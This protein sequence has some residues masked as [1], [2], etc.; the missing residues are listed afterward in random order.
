MIG[1]DH[2][3]VLG[4]NWKKSSDNWDI[5]VNFGSVAF[6]LIM[7]WLET[8]SEDRDVVVN[9]SP[10]ALC[11]AFTDPDN[12]AT[13]LLFQLKEGVEHTKV[14]LLHESILVQPHLLFEELIL[15]GFLPRVGACSLKALLVLA[16][17]LRHL[18]IVI[19]PCESLEPISSVPKELI[20]M[21]NALLSASKASIS[22]ITSAVSPPM[23]RQKL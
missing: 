11:N 5:V 14:E 2:E 6:G 20:V 13:L 10:V 12:V 21:M 19:S 22:H 4:M 18:V 3:I 9:L 7:K 17:V 16:V 1:S 15:Q 8:N 23:F